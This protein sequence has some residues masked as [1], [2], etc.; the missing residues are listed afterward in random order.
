MLFRFRFII[1]KVLHNLFVKINRISFIHFSIYIIHIFM[2]ASVIELNAKTKRLK[3][4]RKKRTKP[5]LYATTIRTTKKRYS[6]KIIAMPFGFY[7]FAVFISN[8]F[9]PFFSYFTIVFLFHYIFFLCNHHKSS[10]SISRYMYI[11]IICMYIKKTAPKQ[12]P[13]CMNISRNFCTD[14][15]DPHIKLIN[16][17]SVAHKVN[18]LRRFSNK[19]EHLFIWIC[20]KKN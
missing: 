19:L 16:Q 4:T 3:Y 1:L 20:T 18:D 7:I 11:I 12:N 15:P 10:P 14:M 5:E 2:L 6:I 9:S 8:W 13:R 17:L